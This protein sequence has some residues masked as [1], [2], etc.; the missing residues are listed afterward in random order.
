MEIAEVKAF[1]EREG[2]TQIIVTFLDDDHIT[3]GVKVKKDGFAAP[4]YGDY[5]VLN[6]EEHTEEK[7]RQSVVFLIE[8]LGEALE[9]V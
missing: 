6:A 1:A 4:T 8:R 9:G 5:V 2:A 7:I 3:V